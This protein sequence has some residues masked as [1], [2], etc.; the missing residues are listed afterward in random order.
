MV[1]A[2]AGMLRTLQSE[3]LPK[4]PSLARAK[5]G[6]QG[7]EPAASHSLPHFSNF[8]GLQE[9]F[10]ILIKVGQFSTVLPFF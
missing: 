3:V 6:W 1:L 10:G 4:N 7:L 5:A 9:T 8:V 2:R